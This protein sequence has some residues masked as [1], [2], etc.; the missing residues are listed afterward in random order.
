MTT[1]GRPRGGYKE[2]PDI[3][4][5]PWIRDHLTAPTYA[6][7]LYGDYKAAVLAEPL[8]IKQKASGRPRKGGKRRV[9]SLHGFMTYLYICRRLGLI[10][11][12]GD[13]EV[14]DMPLGVAAIEPGGQ[15]I[16]QPARALYFEMV[17]GQRGSIAWNNLWQAYR[18]ALG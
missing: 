3:Q 18:E 12:T 8:H 11:Y 14:A 4:L 5:G 2:N 16:T 15:T 13:T 6:G 17:P 7:Q 1:G 9:I 10:R